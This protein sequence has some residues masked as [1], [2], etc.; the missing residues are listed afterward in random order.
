MTSFVYEEQLKYAISLF[1]ELTDHVEI[2]TKGAFYGTRPFC[3]R[4]V[5]LHFNKLEIGKSKIHDWVTYIELNASNCSGIYLHGF[6]PRINYYDSKGDYHRGEANHGEICEWYTSFISKF[7]SYSSRWIA[8]L[9]VNPNQNIF[10]N[11]LDQFGW[12][13]IKCKSNERSVPNIYYSL[14]LKEK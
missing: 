12:K 10:Y 14:V 2:V 8:Q 4:E 13:G 11:N 6:G 9:S 1:P 3:G 7:M 5:M